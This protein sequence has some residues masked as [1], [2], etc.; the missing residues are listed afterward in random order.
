MGGFI[1][2][3]V[4]SKCYALSWS[5]GEIC[6]GSN[7]CGRWGKGLKMWEARLHYH[8]K[9][10]ESDINFNQWAEGYPELIKIQKANRKINISYNKAKIR[11]CK[12]VIKRL[13][14]KERSK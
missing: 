7:C 8:E 14:I 6:V 5:Y 4:T 3:P 9:E 10:L 12:K 13:Q 1:D 2:I 11:Y